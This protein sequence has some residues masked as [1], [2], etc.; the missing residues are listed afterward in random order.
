VG[1]GRDYYVCG[2]DADAEAACVA[3]L[4]TND[5]LSPATPWQSYAQAF[6]TFSSLL[7]GDPIRFCR[8]GAFAVE[9]SARWVNS[10]CRAAQPCLIS[11]CLPAWADASAGLPI[12]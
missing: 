3:G 7:A 9:K 8:G 10:R 1:T 4:D 5:G 11:D 6:A 2:C 12:I